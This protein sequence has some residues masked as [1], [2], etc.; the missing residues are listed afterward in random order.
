MKEKCV[1]EHF[2]QIYIKKFVKPFSIPEFLSKVL[3]NIF[4][5]IFYQEMCMY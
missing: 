3:P 2:Q 4:L 1:L 5:H